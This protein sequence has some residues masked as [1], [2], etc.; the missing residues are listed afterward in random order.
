MYSFIFSVI[1]TT[2]VCFCFFVFFLCGLNICQQVGC[3]LL[4]EVLIVTEL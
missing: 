3:Y 2:G 1:P 4:W